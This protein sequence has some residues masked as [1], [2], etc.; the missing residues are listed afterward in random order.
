ML[1]RQNGSEGAIANLQLVTPPD[2]WLQ[3]VLKK[4]IVVHTRAGLSIDGVLMEHTEDGLIL[5]AAK[6]LG[7]DG[8][9][10]SMAG[11][12]WVPRENVAFAQLDE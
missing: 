4:R 9:Q 11:E 1:G 10:T 12:T 7:D 8:K 3:R 5:R 6:L 2:R